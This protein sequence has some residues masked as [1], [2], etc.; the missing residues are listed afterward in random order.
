MSDLGFQL[1]DREDE[2]YLMKRAA[3]EEHREASHYPWVV[4]YEDMVNN[5]NEKDSTAEV[6]E[7]IV[8]CAKGG[9]RKPLHLRDRG[10]PRSPAG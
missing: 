10:D 3:V 4:E 8:R 9:C 1:P 7:D 6:E 5:F 2:E